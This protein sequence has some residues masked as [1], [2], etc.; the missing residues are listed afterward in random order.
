MVLCNDPRRNGLL[1]RLKAPLSALIPHSPLTLSGLQ[2]L[3]SWIV[4]LLLVLL[5]RLQHSL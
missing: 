2:D 1:L 3:I 4:K 5:V